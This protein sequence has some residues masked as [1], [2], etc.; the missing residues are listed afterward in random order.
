M[1][2]DLLAACEGLAAN[3]YDEDDSDLAADVVRWK[4]L[5]G[6]TAAEAER[7]IR[8]WRSSIGRKSLCSDA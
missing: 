4:N 2:L 7:E 3:V 1:D 5:F 6:L 8:E